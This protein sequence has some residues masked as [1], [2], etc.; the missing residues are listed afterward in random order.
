MY[1][2]IMQ[3]LNKAIAK[4]IRTKYA[5]GFTMAEIADDY[6]VSINSISE[7]VNNKTYY[8]SEYTRPH[9]LA[10]LINEHIIDKRKD[11]H[12]NKQR[13]RLTKDSFIRALA[14]IIEGND[15]E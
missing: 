4:D 7:I 13:E 8:D 1:S 12:S 3:K 10:C 15:N 9:T 2:F 6:H 14:E 11:K 5:D